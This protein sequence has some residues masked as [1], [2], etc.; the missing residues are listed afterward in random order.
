M[1]VV[2]VQCGYD[3]SGTPPVYKGV[4]IC[5]EC[6]KVNIPGEPGG[7]PPPLSPWI[8]AHVWVLGVAGLTAANVA[9]IWTICAAS[10]RPD[11]FV[12]PVYAAIV[13]SL[14]EGLGCA[15]L[16]KRRAR[17]LWVSG[18]V[19]LGLSVLLTVTTLGAFMGA[20]FMVMS[21]IRC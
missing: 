17:P 11:V 5:S 3:L 21:G 9:L 2:C 13:L 7:V 19:W 14:T 16:Q 18:A 15:L 12:F 10:K 20:V 1:T 6:A 4:R 8:R